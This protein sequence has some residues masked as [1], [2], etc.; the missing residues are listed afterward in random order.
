LEDSG[1]LVMAGQ[2]KLVQFD[3]CFL[4]KYLHQSTP[5][6][7]TRPCV[8][9]EIVIFYCFGRVHV[10]SFLIVQKRTS[11]QNKILGWK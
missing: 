10:P 1:V 11:F 6:L 4:P 7:A 9:A 2:S 3:Y 5:M 8:F